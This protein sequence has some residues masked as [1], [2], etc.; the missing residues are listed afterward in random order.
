[1]GRPP[2]P[3]AAGAGADAGRDAGRRSGTAAIVPWLHARARRG[4]AYPALTWQGATRSFAALAAAADEA[5]RRLATLGITRGA[6]VALLAAPA[7]HVV[8]I[9]HAVQRLGATL[10]PLNTRLTAGELA[11]LL[12]VARPAVVLH[13]RIHA[14]LASAATATSTE[15]VGCPPARQAIGAALDRV[16]RAAAAVLRA[17]LDAGAVHSILFTSG[18]SGRP[19]GAMLTHAN[20][21]ASARAAAAH[22]GLGAGDRWLVCMPLFHV[23]GLSIVVRS[24]VVGFPLTLQA[25]FD[26][27]AANRAIVDG[28]VTIVSVVPPMLDRMLDA[29]GARRYPPSLRIVLAG[30]GPLPERL[31][32]RAREH[33]VPVLPTYGLTEA[34]SQVATARPAVPAAGLALLPGMAVRIRAA[35]RD[36][37]GEILARGP[38][39]MRGYLDDAAGTAAALAGGWLH[40]GDLGRIAPDGTL[41]VVG[42]RT[43]LIVTGGENVYPIEVERALAAHPDVVEAAVYGV[44]DDAWGERVVAAVVSRSGALDA[45]ALR[46]W[47]APRLA[48]FKGPREIVLLE[49]LPRTAS[50]KVRYAALRARTPG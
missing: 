17:R 44:A 1:M 13:D 25:G 9:V 32:A 27:D 33:G 3:P 50:G 15:A 20:H 21:A 40:T 46:A 29:L 43:D 18:T 22:L 23:G 7:P 34:A 2:A 26:P 39:V 41:A 6:R 28:G 12:A 31:A 37:V 24:A 10:V 8:E 11:V 35:G 38:A 42:R 4:G 48:G 16:P 5:A 14:A 19:K 30:G 45:P 47:C 36:G 49:R